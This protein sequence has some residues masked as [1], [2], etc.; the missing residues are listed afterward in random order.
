MDFDL[1]VDLMEHI[2]ANLPVKVEPN[3][4]SFIVCQSPLNPKSKTEELAKLMF[5]KFKICSKLNE[6]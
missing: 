6:N 1:M 3:E 2:Y 4:S 5:E